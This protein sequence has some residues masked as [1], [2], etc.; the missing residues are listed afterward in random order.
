MKSK[1]KAKTKPKSKDKNDDNAKL[2]TLLT[3][4]QRDLDLAESIWNGIVEKIRD[5]PNQMNVRG[6]WQRDQ[7]HDL[8]T[9]HAV[10]NVRA[11]FVRDIKTI[12]DGKSP[13]SHD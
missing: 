13:I 3:Y 5:N 8:L 11:G 2:K 12:M 9:C 1:S 4:A 7:L 6:V 10:V